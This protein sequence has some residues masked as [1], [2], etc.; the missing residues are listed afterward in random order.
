MTQAAVIRDIAEGIVPQRQNVTE[1]VPFNLM[2]SEQLVWVMDGVDCLEVVTRRERRGGIH[3]LRLMPVD[4]LE[5][6]SL[7]E[8]DLRLS[9]AETARRPL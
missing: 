9:L 5:M 8:K 4:A 6:T 7:D 1:R 3:G 2:K